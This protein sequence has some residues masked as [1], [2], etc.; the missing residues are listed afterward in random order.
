MV[1]LQELRHRLQK[2]QNARADAERLLSKRSSDL[3]NST[4]QVSQLALFPELSPQPVM[5][6][7]GEARLVL[8]NPK[9]IGLFNESIEEDI[10]LFELFPDAPHLD[11]GDLIAED[12]VTVFNV[13]VNKAYYQVA[14]RGVSDFNFFN[15]YLT[16]I[17][18]LEKAKN[19]MEEARTETEQL[20]ASISSALI[21][22]DEHG[23]ITR[24]NVYAEKVF[25]ILAHEV[26]GH[27]IDNSGIRWSVGTFD[28]IR[29]MMKKEKVLNL[30][31]VMYYRKGEESERCFNANLT[32]IYN[33][34]GTTVGYL[35]LARDITRRKNLEQQLMQA[36]KLESIGQL[37][38]GIAHEINTPIQ[39]I[40]DNTHF[41][42]SAFERIDR[43][44]TVGERLI[45]ASKE[46]DD[47]D[48]LIDEIEEVFTSAKIAYMRQEIPYAISE[49]INGLDQV[50]SIVKG[51]KQFSHPGE[52]EKK[53]VDINECIRNMITVSRN[54][55]KYAAELETQLN[56][57]IP[58]VYCNANEI[59]QVF[60]N[61][62]VNAAHAIEQVKKEGKSD[63]GK[64][65]IQTGSGDNSV[66]VE[67]SDT[68]GGIPKAIQEKIFDPFFTTKE[69]G[70]GTGQGLAIAHNVVVNKHAGLITFSV[71]EGVGTTFRVTLPVMNQ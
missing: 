16:D 4:Q 46:G 28:I 59:N 38:A 62:I 47:V 17:T 44:L 22:M 51:M 41:L 56:N 27:H 43:V 34:G 54:E 14:I 30:E 3:F 9:A 69:P 21:G 71:E 39:F 18:R 1:E 57:A 45:Q 37:A 8:A 64:I 13:K 55:W 50:A 26:L 35:L 60:L 23:I 66:F 25:G 10:T 5:R 52:G 36:Q 68:G 53:L 15:V 49:S 63:R 11:I 70:K 6:F 7:N 67:I 65:T 19:D 12:S 32:K 48:A 33:A 61:I 40:G 42:A 31:N 29:D 2:E 20:L 24:W 58:F